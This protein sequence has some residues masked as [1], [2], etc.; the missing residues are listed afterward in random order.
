MKLSQY[1]SNFSSWVIAWFIATLC[2]TCF[3][4]SASNI[5]IADLPDSMLTEDKVY[6][7]TFSDPNMAKSIIDEMRRRKLLPEH[8]LDFIEGDLLVNNH[9]FDEAAVLYL[10]ALESD[11]VKSD[12]N[13]RM[14]LLH[15][16]IT[17]YDGIHDDKNTTK[18]VKLL[19]DEARKN[20]NKPMESIALFNM[21]KLSYYQEDEELAYKLMYEA[22]DIMKQSDYPYKYDNLRYDYNTL[23]IMLQRDERYEEAYN[24]LLGLESVVTASTAAEPEIK[25]LSQKE[26]KTLYA[27]QAIVLHKLGRDDEA[28]KAYAKWK[29]AA[30]GYR[31][32]DYII[33]PYL[34]NSGRAAEAI[35]I[36]SDYENSLR[37]RG[38]TISY[39][40]RSMLRSMG[41]TYYRVGRYKNAAEYFLRLANVTDSLKVRE[42]NSSAQELATAYDTHRKETELIKRSNS[43]R[44]RNAWL[45]GTVADMT[46]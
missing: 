17:C 40:M 19:L 41:V 43:L 38:D 7:L 33:A 27:Q 42:Q 10:E 21:G 39:H 6:E 12:P 11:S 29:L 37:E 14:S 34:A 8:E 20:H 44:L 22:I 2:S 32:D 46:L 4:V 15:R 3:P 24:A 31:A 9:Y 36:Y 35:K 16:M 30:P 1:I 18:Y 23:I 28:E 5:G 26:L 45:V 13:T 25:D